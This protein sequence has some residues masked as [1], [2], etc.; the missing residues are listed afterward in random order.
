MIT[1]CRLKCFVVLFFG[2]TI[3]YTNILNASPIVTTT[4]ISF[5]KLNYSPYSNND[6]DVQLNWAYGT[7]FVISY[8]SGY[9]TPLGQHI[10]TGTTTLNFNGWVLDT[11]PSVYLASPNDLFSTTAISANTFTPLFVGPYGPSNSLTLDTYTSFYLGI[12]NSRGDGL[13]WVQLLDTGTGLQMIDN[14]IAYGSNGIYVGTLNTINP[15]PLPPAVAFFA[16]GLIGVFSFSRRKKT[17]N[18]NQLTP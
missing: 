2:M 3:G 5:G 12:L 14:A 18:L 9:Y 15:V 7:D 16:T 6:Y 13:G 1:K 11:T 17:E 4:D 10:F 8:S